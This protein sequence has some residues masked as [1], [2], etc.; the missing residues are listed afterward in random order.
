VSPTSRSA[1]STVSRES[2]LGLG[3]LLSTAAVAVEESSYARYTRGRE[4]GVL[5][6]GG[7][8]SDDADGEAG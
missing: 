8:L 2:P 5:L 7:L 6:L 3:T 4:V 1:G